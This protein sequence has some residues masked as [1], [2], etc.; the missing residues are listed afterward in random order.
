MSCFKLKSLRAYCEMTDY[1]EDDVGKFIHKQKNLE[2]LDLFVHNHPSRRLMKAICRSTKLEFLSM[3]CSLDEDSVDFIPEFMGRLNNTSVKQLHILDDTGFNRHLI[4]IFT[5]VTSIKLLNNS[6]W[7]SLHDVSPSCGTAHKRTQAPA[8]PV[9]EIENELTRNRETPGYKAPVYTGNRDYYKCMTPLE[10]EWHVTRLKVHRE[11]RFDMSEKA[12]TSASG[13]S[14]LSKQ[15]PDSISA[16][17]KRRVRLKNLSD[18]LSKDVYQCIRCGD[19]SDESRICDKCEASGTA[20]ILNNFVPATDSTVNHNYLCNLLDRR[21][22]KACSNLPGDPTQ[23]ECMAEAEKITKEVVQAFIDFKANNPSTRRSRCHRRGTRQDQQ[24]S[25]TGTAGQHR[26]HL[27]RS[28]VNG[29]S[30]RFRTCH[31]LFL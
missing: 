6:R 7:L 13:E 23:L 25:G 15:I 8:V 14:T 2:P 12:Q 5:G 22:A 9:E 30:L 4:K 27:H 10:Y 21:F 18:E 11:S 17:H 3:R 28:F 19:V 29:H 16:P 31:T 20:Q 24:I 1:L 26:F